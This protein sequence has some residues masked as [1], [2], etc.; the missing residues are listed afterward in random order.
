MVQAP[1]S[2]QWLVIRPK[3]LPK[4]HLEQASSTLTTTTVSRLMF[5]VDSY[6]ALRPAKTLTLNSDTT[7]SLNQ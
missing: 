3:L 2:T 4:E 5:S 1:Y 6:P 7:L